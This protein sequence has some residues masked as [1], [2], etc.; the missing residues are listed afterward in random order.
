VTGAVRPRMDVTAL[1]AWVAAIPAWRS[2]HVSHSW[3]E[4]GKDRVEAVDDILLAADHHAVAT[5][6]TPDAAARSNIDIMQT[7][8]LE[9]CCA[10]NV[11]IVHSSRAD[12]SAGPRRCNLARRDSAP[13]QP[14]WIAR[15]RD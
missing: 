8:L 12:N 3:C 9:R 10:A 11:V 13:N 4:R 15:Y 1:C 5:F 6:Q 7:A 2:R 14:Q